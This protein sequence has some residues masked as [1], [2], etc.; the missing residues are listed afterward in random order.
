MMQELRGKLLISL[1]HELLVEPLK[2]LKVDLAL[3]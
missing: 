2:L 3:A 1:H